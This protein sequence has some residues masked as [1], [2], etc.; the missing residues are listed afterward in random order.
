M[1]TRIALI[2]GFVL[3]GTLCAELVFPDLTKSEADE[4]R[5]K[6]EGFDTGNLALDQFPEIGKE[7]LGK[8][9]ISYYLSNSNKVTIKMKLPVARC[10][11]VFG[12][13][14]EAADLTASYVNTYSNDWRGW[15]QL[16][17][18]KLMLEQFDES[19]IALTNSIRLGSDKNIAGAGLAALTTERLDI[20]ES[21]LLKRMI[22][23]KDAKTN[24]VHELVSKKE[25]VE[26]IT[27]LVAYSLKAKKESVFIEALKNVNATE[28]E[29]KKALAA[30]VEAGCMLFKGEETSKL[31]NRLAEQNADALKPKWK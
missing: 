29:S 14:R 6:L 25:R 21:I 15:S 8:Q 9:I 1:I 30:Y 3:C 18:A 11:A 26:I 24:S 31:C 16:G 20:F 10:Y 4:A 23:L 22:V 17:G 2:L 13:Y 7:A 19:L 28:V 12:F 5:S 27:M